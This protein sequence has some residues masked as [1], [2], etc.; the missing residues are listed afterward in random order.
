MIEAQIMIK[1]QTFV[2]STLDILQCCMHY[3]DLTLFY[4]VHLVYCMNDTWV[5]AWI[6]LDLLH[7]FLLTL[8]N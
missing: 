1:D 4:D 2:G 3:I 7:V 8:D 5:I 6:T